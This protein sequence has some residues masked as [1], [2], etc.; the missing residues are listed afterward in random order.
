MTMNYDDE[1]K[2]LSLKSYV[3]GLKSQTTKN[4]VS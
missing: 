4:L 2:V 1:L 3:S